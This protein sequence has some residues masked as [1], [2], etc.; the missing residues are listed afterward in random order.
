V[1]KYRL[2]KSF[3]LFCEAAAGI[4]ENSDAL[5]T[6]GIAMINIIPTTEMATMF[7]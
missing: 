4:H 5:V 2:G 3:T 6:V 1:R 7:R